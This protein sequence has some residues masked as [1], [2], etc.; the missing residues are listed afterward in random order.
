MEAAI[1]DLLSCFQREKISTNGSQSTV[2]LEH[3]F[4]VYVNLVS[5]LVYSN[6]TNRPF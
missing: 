2:S 4:L 1:Y 5:I 3:S 6:P